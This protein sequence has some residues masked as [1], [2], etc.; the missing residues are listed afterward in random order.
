[1]RIN[2]IFLSIDGEVNGFDGQGQPTVFIRFQGCSAGC[3]YCDTKYAQ[4]SLG[5][6]EMTIKEIIKEVKGFEIDKVT[7]TGGEP[8]EQREMLSELVQKLKKRI[9]IETNGL[10]YLFDYNINNVRY[11]MDYKLDSSGLK[12]PKEI[13]NFNLMYLKENDWI[14]FVVGSKRDFLIALKIIKRFSFNQFKVAI[15]PIYGIV[16]PQQLLDWMGESKEF[17]HI[18]C[19]LHKL[20]EMR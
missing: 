10:H 1:M 3:R 19:Q 4:D 16:E 13:V 17:Y 6:E 14:K 5:G 9:T 2:E 8:F 12:V 20:V 7:I 11:V 15:S 18:N